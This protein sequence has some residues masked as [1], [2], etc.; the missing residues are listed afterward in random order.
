MK[1]QEMLIRSRFLAVTVALIMTAALGVL[2]TSSRAGAAV[3]GVLRVL[4]PAPSGNG[5]ALAFDSTS[6]HLFY[7]NRDEPQIFVIDTAGHLVRTLNPTDAGVPIRYGALSWQATASGGVLWGGRYD[8]SGRVDRIDPYTG[9]VKRMF[10]FAFP[11]GDSCYPQPS[12]L[13]DGLAFDQSDGTLWLGDDAATV[14]FHVTASGTK[15]GTFATPNRLCRSGIAVDSGFLWL[16]LQAGA[17][18]PP[19][20]LGRVAK[21]HPTALLESINFGT[22]AGPEGLAMDHTTFAG[23]CAMWSNQFGL[24]TILKAWQLPSALCAGLPSLRFQRQVIDAASGRAFTGVVLVVSDTARLNTPGLTAAINWGDG[25]RPSTGLVLRLPFPLNGYCS[26]D[27]LPADTCYAV[28]GTHTYRSSGLYKPT[29]VLTRG[30]NRLGATDIAD[31]QPF[32]GRP[33]QAGII[34]AQ[35]SV[36]GAI[37]WP[38]TGCTATALQNTNIVLTAH[39]CAPGGNWSAPDDVWEFSPAH[40]GTCTSGQFDI[41]PNNPDGVFVTTG[42]QAEQIGAS[43]IELVTF[44]NPNDKGNYLRSYN[45]AAFEPVFA[46]SASDTWTSFGYPVRSFDFSQHGCVPTAGTSSATSGTIL[47]PGCD[48]GF[49]NGNAG[50]ISGSPWVDVTHVPPGVGAVEH[51]ICPANTLCGSALSQN[52]GPF[53]YATTLGISALNAFI[54]LALQS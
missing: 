53:A 33:N 6:G 5:R 52:P 37:D 30:G 11:A 27:Q 26:V 10:A 20:M 44:P 17:D 31:V 13:I 8:G 24:Q 19:Y 14:F 46:V 18:Q 49:P 51:G 9:A 4:T 42:A 32:T 21:S 15:I 40:S 28:E 36:S 34:A 29:V 45:Y 48:Y 1:G 23:L 22:A 2:A 12:G 54:N 38:H 41:C 25:S 16:G 43:D 47:L 3:G 7:T 35:D 39:H 50:G